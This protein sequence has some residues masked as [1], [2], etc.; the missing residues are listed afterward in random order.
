MIT[1]RYLPIPT[2]FSVK[3]EH[4]MYHKV[5]CKMT[6]SLVC[7]NIPAQSASIIKSIYL[8][9]HIL[10]TPYTTSTSSTK[11]LRTSL[12]SLSPSP[13]SIT[14]FKKYLTY[15]SYANYV[16]L[17]LKHLVFPNPQ[18]PES[19]LNT[20]LI[21]LCMPTHSPSLI[22]IPLRYPLQIRIINLRER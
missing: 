20:L 4:T 18:C 11:N 10:Y 3:R 6:P 15:S 8:Q 1:H 17:H 19:I 2:S 12:I 13:I 9:S 14:I 21:F 7:L 16:H 5:R 22:L